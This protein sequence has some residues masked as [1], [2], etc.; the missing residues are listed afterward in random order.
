MHQT[1]TGTKKT[2]PN[3][4]SKNFTIYLGRGDYPSKVF[5]FL[6]LFVPVQVWCTLKFIIFCPCAGLVDLEV[7]KVSSMMNPHVNGIGEPPKN[8]VPIAPNDA[9]WRPL[10]G[11]SLAQAANFLKFPH[12]IGIKFKGI[13]FL[14]CHDKQRCDSDGTAQTRMYGHGLT[15]SRPCLKETY[16][17][18]T[19]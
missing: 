9:T 5:V 15:C 8:T 11:P 2:K 17:E 14:L 3:T 16:T 19:F 12:G 1:C 13:K 10:M 7:Q 18:K 6:C 4:K